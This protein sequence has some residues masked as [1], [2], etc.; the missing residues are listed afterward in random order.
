MPVKDEP[1]HQQ[2]ITVFNFEGYP[3][4][5]ENLAAAMRSK[6]LPIQTRE[7]R[8]MDFEEK[9]F[10]SLQEAATSYLDFHLS[11]WKNYDQPQ[12]HMVPPVFDGQQ[13]DIGVTF[14]DTAQKM[15]LK[16]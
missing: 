4:F 16:A 5:A 9:E 14:G 8:F 1:V 7:I 6:N 2:L 15:P 3:E 10:D 11:N 13:T 12:S